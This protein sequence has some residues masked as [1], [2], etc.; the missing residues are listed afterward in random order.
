MIVTLPSEQD[1]NRRLTGE[2]KQFFPTVLETVDE[3]EKTASR[4][5]RDLTPTQ[6]FERAAVL[7]RRLSTP[8]TVL[9]GHS[10]R[11]HG[12]L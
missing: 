12:L 5:A 6:S 2:F 1:A 11:L 9:R 4:Q 3:L 7:A 10:R 8:S